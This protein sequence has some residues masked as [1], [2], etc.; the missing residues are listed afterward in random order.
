MSESFK[1]FAF[2]SYNS[3][4][5]EWGK[6]LQRKLEGYKMPSTLCSEK[7]WERKPIHPV[8]FA[9]TD[10]QPDD[11]NEEIKSR[12]RASRNLIVICSPNSAKSDWVGREIEYFHSLGRGSSIRFFI[13]DGIPNSGDPDTEC[14]NDVV[15]QLG[16]RDVLGVNIN[17]EN[18]KLRYLNR[19]RAYVQ[20]ITKLLG[21]EFDDIWQRHKRLMARNVILIVGVII[22]VLALVTWAW[23]AHRPVE[24]AITLT[25]L[26][27]HNDN[28][29]ELSDAEITLSVGDY[30]RKGR[31]TALDGV[32]LLDMVPHNLLGMKAR[33]KF[34]DF[35]DFPDAMNYYPEELEV[36]LARE[37]QIAIRRDTI[38]YGHLRARFVD[39]HYRPIPHHKSTVAGIAIEADAQGYIDM[40]IPFSRQAESYLVEQDSLT[41]V[42][43]TSCY[44][45]IVEK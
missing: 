28:L 44:V 14:Y 3:R 17:E 30:E 10:I 11:L 20:L 4:D 22:T 24:I 33:L 31:I 9:P 8:F 34:I 18:F 35:P 32:V 37:M 41:N 45:V 7:G 16:M 2:I 26:T 27:P 6:R 23:R 29:P 1:Y 25:E 5:V 42:G 12:L 21:I 36:T 39:S 19:E 40:H 15:R 13:I 38:K 43:L